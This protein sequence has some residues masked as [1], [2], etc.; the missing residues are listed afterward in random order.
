MVLHTGPGVNYPAD[1]CRNYSALACWIHALTMIDRVLTIAK[2]L[3][4]CR[5]G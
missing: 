2:P 3:S 4:A 5:D 1:A